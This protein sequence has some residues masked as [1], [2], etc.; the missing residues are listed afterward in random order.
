VELRRFPVKAAPGT[1]VVLY[2]SAPTMAVVGIAVLVDVV[3]LRP[4]TAWRRYRS[5]PSLS[6]PGF[7]EYLD[8][9]EQA[10][11][12]RLDDVKALDRP[13]PAGILPSGT[14]S[15]H[16]ASATSSRRTRASS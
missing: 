11:L 13:A 5:A 12:I 14:V 1:V 16:T 8:G 10:H 7:Y 6:W 4:C 9:A 15:T 2:A 3:A